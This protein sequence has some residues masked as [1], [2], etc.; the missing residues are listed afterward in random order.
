MYGFPNL[1]LCKIVTV[2]WIRKAELD[3]A[4]HCEIKLL[5][6][7]TY[8]TT[9]YIIHIYISTNHFKILSMYNDML[10][11]WAVRE[12]VKAKKRW[13]ASLCDKR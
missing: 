10:I 4:V 2:L 6:P 11:K 1:F 8:Y 12:N 3:I 7:K 13:S 5:T 9:I